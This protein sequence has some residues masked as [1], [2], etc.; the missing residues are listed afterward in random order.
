VLPEK[1]QTSTPWRYLGWQITHVPIKPQKISIPLQ[2][3][4]LNELQNVLGT[5]NWLCPVIGLS[6]DDL[7]SLFEL[8]KGDPNLTSPRALTPEAEHSLS[9]ITNKI[10]VLQVH[11][12]LEH[13]EAV[14]IVLRGPTQP[15]ALLGQL[16]ANKIKMCLWEWIFLPHQF[17]KTL[18]SLPEL[19]AKLCFRG[20]TRCWELMGSDPTEIYLPITSQHLE[21]LLVM[22]LDFR[23]A[24]ADFSG[25]IK[26]IHYPPCKFVQNINKIPLKYT[27]NWSPDPIP[28][29]LTIFTDG[30][31]TTGNAV[32]VWKWQQD[33][34]HVSG[35]P[36]LV[37]LSAVVCALFPDALNIVSASAYV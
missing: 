6:T 10:N 34:H 35:S 13:E 22:S 3:T 2:V 20:R 36:Q 27:S 15:F 32:I 12:R 14:L 19:L 7:H 5:L 8:L 1:I 11:R 37:E 16:Y 4:T 24:L 18:V 9:I 33:I 28:N 17:T 29:A 31:G 23:I 21:Q 30:S 25:S 26:I